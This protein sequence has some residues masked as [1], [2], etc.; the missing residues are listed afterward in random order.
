MH[1]ADVKANGCNATSTECNCNTICHGILSHL[2]LT[3]GRSGIYSWKKK[4]SS[5]DEF[6]LK[7]SEL[8]RAEL[9]HFNF[10]ADTELTIS[11]R[12]GK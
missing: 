3:Y 5:S 9:G 10:R 11:N 1:Y 4:L 6:E 8:S 7:F 2:S 12:L